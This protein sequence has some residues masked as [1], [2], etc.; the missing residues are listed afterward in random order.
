MTQMKN[1]TILLSIFILLLSA[2]S[3][4]DKKAGEEGDQK[5]RVTTTTMMIHDAVQVIGGEQ[6]ISESL[7]GPGVDPHLYKATQGDLRKLSDADVILYNGLY[8]EGKLGE[9]FKKLERRKPVY[10]VAEEALKP[11]K[12]LSS[13]VYQDAFDPH[14]WF[15]VSMWKQVVARVGEVLANEDPTHAPIYKERTANYLAELDDLHTWVKEQ[16]ASIP[17]Q[18]R[19]LVTAHDAFHYFGRA[20]DIKVHGL[21]GISTITEPGLKDV[22]ELTELITANSIKAVFVETSVSEKMIQAV[23]EGCE[24]KGHKVVIGGYLYS[25]AMG[26]RGTPAATYKGMVHANVKTIVSSLK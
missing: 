18:Q 6:V 21:Q 23:V 9:V 19:I 10:A 2:C 15:D 8:L 20:Y 5:L 25:D 7:M 14:V 22:T 24:D 3:G 26:E 16:I 4:G 11:E 12:L 1:S 17:E 13:P